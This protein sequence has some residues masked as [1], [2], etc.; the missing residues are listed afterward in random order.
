VP[1]KDTDEFA[2]RMEQL[3]RDKGLARRLGRRGRELL[4]QQQEASSQICPVEE[5]LLR[6]AQRRGRKTHYAYET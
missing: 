2:A 3:L 1:W 4:S 5:I 6:V